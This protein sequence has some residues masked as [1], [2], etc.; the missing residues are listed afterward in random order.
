MMVIPTCQYVYSAVVICSFSFTL[1]NQIALTSSYK[2]WFPHTAFLRLCG[3]F[4]CCTSRPVTCKQLA[5]QLPVKC[6]TACTSSV[7]FKCLYCTCQYYCG[8]F[9][10]LACGIKVYKTYLN[11]GVVY[12]VCS[13][14][15]RGTKMENIRF[16]LLNI[17]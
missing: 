5:D 15:L 7:R 13:Y 4:N 2:V 8:Y 9:Y 14:R 6:L 12:T 11:I 10:S 16:I 3:I 1:I 17:T